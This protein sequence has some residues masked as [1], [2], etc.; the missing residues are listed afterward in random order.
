MYMFFYMDQSIKRFPSGYHQ[1]PIH[2]DRP[3][4]CSCNTPI[5]GMIRHT[6]MVWFL[7]DLIVV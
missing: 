5:H 4:C 2:I 7:I 1:V 6:P 3:Q